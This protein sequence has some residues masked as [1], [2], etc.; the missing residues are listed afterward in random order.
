MQLNVFTYFY[1]CYCGKEGET[2]SLLLK[3][4]L[5]FSFISY[6]W[7]KM[8]SSVHMQYAFR[9]NTD[10]LLLTH[11]NELSE[12][13]SNQA[14]KRILLS[15]RF[16]N[17]GFCTLFY[18]HCYTN[19]VRD[20]EF[21]SQAS[22]ICQFGSFCSIWIRQCIALTESASTSCLMTPRPYYFSPKLSFPEEKFS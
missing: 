13:R 21:L 18:R 20:I 5:N 10:P 8:V 3:R 2:M 7:N 9:I 4:K 14:V 1:C 11:L 17:Y 15:D 16:C 19:R 6:I 12:H 22:Q